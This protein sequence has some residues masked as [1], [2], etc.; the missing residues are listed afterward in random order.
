MPGET[1][2]TASNTLDFVNRLAK[3]NGLAPGKLTKDMAKNTE[4]MALFSAKG[5]KGFATAAVELHKMGVEI[6]TASKSALGLLDFE[7]SINKQME[8]SVLL[9]RQINFDKARE[10][11]LSGDLKGST[12]EVLKNIG[13]MGE[14]ERMSVL[15]KQAL[16]EA[17][18]MTVDEIKKAL[19]A[20]QEYNK[21]HGEEAGIW[22]NTLG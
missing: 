19:D 11:A 9:G 15:Q 17:T 8:A 13:S 2:E 4:T 14:F 12:K 1:M 5:A 18:G 16:A 3:A 10:L 21:Y 22:E 20:Q 6:D 7:S